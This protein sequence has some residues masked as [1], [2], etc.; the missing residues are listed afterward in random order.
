[1]GKI[2]YIRAA[3]LLAGAFS[4]ICAAE[5][6]VVYGERLFF[7]GSEI[8]TSGDIETLPVSSLEEV[9]R[10]SAGVDV[11][12]RGAFGVQNDLSVAGGSFEQVLV[13]LDGM[14]MSDLQTGHHQM[15]IP[16]SKNDIDR[17]E[18]ISAPASSLYGAGAFSGA[19][20]IRRVF[21]RGQHNH[22]KIPEEAAGSG[23][24]FL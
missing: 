8:I 5:E 23:V 2:K 11:R 17:V 3:V 19:V 24:V 14:K 20:N 9:L 7:P 1:M 6:I 22:Q 13:L 15:N 21:W 12:G 10:L 4:A 16:V 18:I